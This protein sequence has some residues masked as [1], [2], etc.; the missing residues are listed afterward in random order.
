MVGGFRIALSHGESGFD[1]N[2]TRGNPV[3]NVP[4]VPYVAGSP[5]DWPQTVLTLV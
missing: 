3:P 5:Y 2:S 4:Y 1:V